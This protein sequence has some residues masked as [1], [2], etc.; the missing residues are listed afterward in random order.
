[1]KRI[2]LKIDV[3]TCRGTLVGVPA[4]IELLQRH[5]A[6]GSFFFSLGPDHSGRE[7]RSLSPS[8]YYDLATR[9]HGR[10]LP[11][12]DIGIRGAGSMRKA[13]A[14][15]FEVAVH[16]WNRVRWEAQ[17]LT[18]ENACIEAEM[19]QAC[20]RFTAV[21]G[22]PPHAHGAAGWRMNRHALRL[23]QR[24]GFCYASDCRGKFPFVPV[25]DGELIHCPQLPTTLPTLDELLFPA[26][27][28]VDQAVDRILDESSGVHGDQVFTL[29]AELEGMQFS[30]ALERL[31]VGWKSRGHQLVALRDLLTGCNIASLPRHSVIFAE[32]P[33][34][35]GPRMVQGPAFLPAE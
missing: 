32:I 1:M 31:L 8:R 18:A 14:A 4:L 27:V 33:G 17:V 26:T 10:L 5:Q 2:A 6:A 25:I 13:Q 35:F 30:T 3:D 9:L 15:G 16:A 20:R 11:A 34:R 21:F 28:S 24:L 7:A 19:E 23:T 29:R 12:P 22:E